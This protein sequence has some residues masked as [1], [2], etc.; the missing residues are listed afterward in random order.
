MEKRITRVLE[1]KAEHERL[2]LKVEELTALCEKVTPT[3][4]GMPKGSA[5]LTDDTWAK[6]MDYKRSCSEKLNE[7]YQMKVEL[8]QEFDRIRNADVRTVLN[9]KYVDGLTIDAIAD[10]MHYSTRTIDRFLRIGR[11]AYRRL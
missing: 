8:E 7:Y 1:C 5:V 3:I 9:Y 4:T 11:D 6:L 2:L 10:R